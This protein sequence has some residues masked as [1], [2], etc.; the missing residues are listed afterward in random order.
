MPLSRSA[1]RLSLTFALLLS[2]Q[3]Q[4]CPQRPVSVMSNSMTTNRVWHPAE[5][6]CINAMEPVP[7]FPSM[8]DKLPLSH[9]FP[10]LLS[11]K[12]ES[13]SPTCDLRHNAF[14]L[15]PP[16]IPNPHFST[17]MACPASDQAPIPLPTH[18]PRPYLPTRN[19]LRANG[20]IWGPPSFFE[21]HA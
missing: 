5:P 1:H 19:H 7:S 17:V 14:S 13:S 15:P 11:A 8:P 4:R 21:W 20:A 16:I 2:P 12:N 3:H 10:F 9:S 6:S 18:L